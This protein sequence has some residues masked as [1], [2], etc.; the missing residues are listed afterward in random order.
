VLT[1]EL[2]S[3]DPAAAWTSLDG[4]PWADHTVVG[5]FKPY[6]GQ[7]AGSVV[8]RLRV[9]GGTLWLCQLPLCAAVVAGDAA[10][11]GI[12]AGLVHGRL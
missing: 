4:Q 8:G 9:A 2:L 3:V 7:L 6:P 5:V 1:T 12:L 10:A 11:A